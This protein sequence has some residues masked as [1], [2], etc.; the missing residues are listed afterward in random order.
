MNTT[1][2]EEFDA[3]AN[4]ATEEEISLLSDEQNNNIY[5]TISYYTITHTR[6][7]ETI[8]N[9]CNNKKPKRHTL[10]N[11]RKIIT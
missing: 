2:V 7:M 9:N 5:N 8:R 3:V 4:T 10:Q 11:V 1:T 6:T